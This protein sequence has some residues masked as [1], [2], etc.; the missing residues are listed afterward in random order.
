MSVSKYLKSVLFS[1][2]VYLPT[3]FDFHF[4]GSKKNWVPWSS[5]VSKY[6]HN[7]DMKFI[8]VLGKTAF[9]CPVQFFHSIFFISVLHTVYMYCTFCFLPVPT[10]D[11]TRAN[12]LLEQ[13]VKV[14]R[15]VVLVGESG[16]SKTATIQNFLNN[17][18]TDTT[19][20]LLLWISHMHVINCVL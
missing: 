7:P 6:V 19:V 3:L 9:F 12:W 17:L 1:F 13:M 2:A 16:T 11:T 4:D 8:D 18:N 14:K 10:V 20:R 5:M 15:P